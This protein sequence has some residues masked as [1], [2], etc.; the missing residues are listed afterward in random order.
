MRNIVL[1]GFMGTGKTEVGKVLSQKLGLSLVDSDHEI[2]KGQGMTIREI[3]KVYGEEGFR[4]RESEVIRNLSDAE[5]VVI[6][7]GGG[8]V[9]RQENME[10]LRKKGVIVCLTASAHGI[11]ERTKH[12]SERPLLQVSDPLQRIRELLDVRGPLYE[13]ADILI[14]TEGKSPL[15]A[16]EE[17]IDRIRQ[18]AQE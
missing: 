3:F 10:N 7:T 4:D 6:A 9:L 12:D 2:E 15:E 5:N 8:V 16:A 1:I 14:D 13:R 18:H 17:I 11:L